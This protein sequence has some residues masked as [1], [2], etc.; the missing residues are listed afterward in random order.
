MI[1]KIVIRDVASYDHEGVTF[2]NLSKV[3]FIYGGNGTGKTTFSRVLE[4]NESLKAKYPGCRVVWDGKPMQVLV[5][6]QDFRRR[7]LSEEIPGVFSIGEPL[8]QMMKRTSEIDNRK[9]VLEGRKDDEAVQE[10]IDIENEKAEIIR[11]FYSTHIPIDHINRVLKLFG[12]TGFSIQ[13]SDK[14]PF[15]YQIEREDGSLAEETLSEGEATFITF[16]YFM[17]QV[18]GGGNN[19]AGEEAKVVVIDDPVSSLDVDVMFV[20]SE[21]LRQMLDVVRERKDSRWR[22]PYLGMKMTPTGSFGFDVSWFKGVQQVFVLTHNVYFHKQ[23]TDRQRVK[24]TLYW[25][26]QKNNG[27]SEALSCGDEN[28]IC[29]E[30]E[31]MW[32]ELRD[33]KK[34][35]VSVGLQNTMRRIIETYFMVM[36]GY[37]KRKLIPDN[38][39]DN[40]EEMLLITSLAKWSDEGSHGAMDEVFAGDRKTINDKY[41]HVF[42]MLFKKL[43]H[44]AHYNMMMRERRFEN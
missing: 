24:N 42:E 16:L 2:D 30:Y 41:L 18:Y 6:N 28:P 26:L 17:Q 44:E 35:K 21:M 3:N 34:G 14:R 7:N 27:V 39:S 43:G 40:P 22:I 9:K 25:K 10:L 11:R 20:V 31:L 38:F 37:D 13:P 12:F 36:G 1:K 15:C 5:Y 23:I 8:M 19:D 33:A 4:A 29:S 32:R